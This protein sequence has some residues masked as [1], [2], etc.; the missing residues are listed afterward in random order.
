[1]A[2]NLTASLDYSLPEYASHM[3]GTQTVPLSLPLLAKTESALVFHQ[4]YW[5]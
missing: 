1:M 2:A 5:S 3:R 4:L